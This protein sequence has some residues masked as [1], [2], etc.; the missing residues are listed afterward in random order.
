MLMLGTEIILNKNLN[1]LKICDLPIRKHIKTV[2]IN[3]LIS[4]R[5]IYQDLSRY[6]KFDGYN[7]DF[8]PE[9][10]T[11]HL[12]NLAAIIYFKNE[13]FIRNC[14]SGFERR[15]VNSGGLKVKNEK[16]FEDYCDELKKWSESGYKNNI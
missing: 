10:T 3:D 14:P 2:K 16:E 4:V 1:R 15:I 8:Y 7:R 12:S 9:F 13:T 6:G 11:K 5:L